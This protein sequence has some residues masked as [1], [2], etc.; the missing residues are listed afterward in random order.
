M[1]TCVWTTLQELPPTP[2]KPI[3][4]RAESPSLGIACHILAV[5]GSK[6]HLAV[7]D[8]KHCSWAP[9]LNSNSKFL[10][11]RLSSEPPLPPSPLR[12][13]ILILPSALSIF[14]WFLD[15]CFSNWELR[16]MNEWCKSVHWVLTSIFSNMVKVALHNKVHQPS[17]IQLFLL[18]PRISRQSVSHRPQLLLSCSESKRTGLERYLWFFVE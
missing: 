11:W 2:G 8:L 15:Q 9:G 3:I 6:T 1:I 18:P 16:P 7:N 12:L 4:A 17:W 14:G 10:P 13:K 5:L